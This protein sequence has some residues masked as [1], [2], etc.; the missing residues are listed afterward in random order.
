MTEKP[1]RLL[2]H[3][4]H[5]KEVLLAMLR[6]ASGAWGLTKTKAFKMLVAIFAGLISCMWLLQDTRTFQVSAVKLETYSPMASKP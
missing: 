5:K 2:Y 3:T 1:F 6:S 4:K